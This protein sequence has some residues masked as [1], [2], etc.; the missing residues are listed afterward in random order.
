MKLS[1]LENGSDVDRIAYNLFSVATI[2][3]VFQEPSLNLK[4]QDTPLSFKDQYSTREHLPEKSVFSIDFPQINPFFLPTVKAV[5]VNTNNSSAEGA[6][7][8]A[9]LC[10]GVRSVRISLSLFVWKRVSL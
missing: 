4:P 6:L 1:V 5:Y 2:W 3:S 8:S 7:L 9:C 10:F